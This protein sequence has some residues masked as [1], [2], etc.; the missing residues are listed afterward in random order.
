[1]D[2]IIEE[3]INYRCSLVQENDLDSIID[4]VGSNSSSVIESIS[5]NSI[6]DNLF[7]L[8]FRRNR[9]AMDGLAVFTVSRGEILSNR[10]QC[11][12]FV[13]QNIM[14]TSTEPPPQ[15]VVQQISDLLYD[16][17]W[18]TERDPLN[19]NH[20]VL[21][22]HMCLTI[23]NSL[24]L[25]P[26]IAV[27]FRRWT[28][29]QRRQKM[30][31]EL[32]VGGGVPSIRRRTAEHRRRRDSESELGGRGAVKRFRADFREEVMVRYRARFDDLKSF[33]DDDEIRWCSICLEDFVAGDLITK[34]FCKHIYHEGCV[35]KWLK[36]HQTCPICRTPVQLDF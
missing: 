22:I 8:T 20:R 34:T 33:F 24:R 31:S 36:I 17:A 4:W 26:G 23:Q 13:N 19:L 27:P 18:I 25:P 35:V 12:R 5:S 2:H 1:M 15:V 32:G 29:E 14:V 9:P 10:E 7:V 6:S 11:L 16:Y 28:A 30:E 3:P 21:M